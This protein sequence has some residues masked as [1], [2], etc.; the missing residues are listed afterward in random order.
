M[1]V[2]KKTVT[3]PSDRRLVIM[4]PDSADPAQVAEVVVSF[5]TVST[6]GDKMALMQGAMSD[7]LFVADLKEVN[8]DFRGCDRIGL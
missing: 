8:R 1:E 6:N 5:S 2:V 3:I 7:P 4:L